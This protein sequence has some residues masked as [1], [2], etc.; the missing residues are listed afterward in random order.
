MQKGIKS[1]NNLVIRVF[2]YFSKTFQTEN[3]IKSFQYNSKRKYI[4]LDN[5]G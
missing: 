2:Y 3:L 5:A 4:L 1:E